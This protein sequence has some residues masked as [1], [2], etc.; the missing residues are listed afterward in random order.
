MSLT[1]D[2]QEVILRSAVLQGCSP[3]ARAVAVKLLVDSRKLPEAFPTLLT[4]VS[5]ERDA[6]LRATEVRLLGMTRDARAVA[7]LVSLMHDADAGVRVA[8]ADALGICHSP[9]WPLDR[10]AGAHFVEVQS[11]PPIR[12]VWTPWRDGLPNAQAGDARGVLEGMMVSAGTREEREAAAR[13][14]VNWP[15]QGT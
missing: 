1:S 10:D 9:I 15:R 4:A 3:H 12:V 8:A 11:D 14:L 5:T 6:G 13:A 2:D 7:L